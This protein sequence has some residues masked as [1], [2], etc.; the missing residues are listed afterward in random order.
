MDVNLLKTKMMIVRGKQKLPEHLINVGF[1]FKGQP[2]P[3]HSRGGDIHWR[4]ATHSWKDMCY[5]AE[6]R[7][8][9]AS[10]ILHAMLS[11]CKRKG[12]YQ[13]AFLCRIS[14]VL[15]LPVLSYGAHVWGPSMFQEYLTDPLHSKNK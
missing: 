3:H 12:I 11:K 10:K 6:H 14:Y 15:A 1:T 9:A 5:A 7:A 4:S 2:G 13:P 8:T